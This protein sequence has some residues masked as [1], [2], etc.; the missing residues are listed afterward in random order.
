MLDQILEEAW[1]E[2]LTGQGMRADL[3]DEQANRDLMARRLMEAAEDG[4]RDPVRLKQHA[5]AGLLQ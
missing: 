2:L 4:E 1:Q 3:E 5:L